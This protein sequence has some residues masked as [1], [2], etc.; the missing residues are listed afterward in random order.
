MAA[1][2]EAGWPATPPAP[3]TPDGDGTPALVV[4]PVAAP[5][6]LP[7]APGVP[8][9]GEIDMRAARF[10]CG[11]FTTGAGGAGVADNAIN[12]CRFDSLAEAFTSGAAEESACICRRSATAAM[13]LI[14]ICG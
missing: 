11:T 8:P 12:R 4:P 7:E 6:A 13:E 10:S 3:F 9:A 2:S 5:A 1:G 14:G